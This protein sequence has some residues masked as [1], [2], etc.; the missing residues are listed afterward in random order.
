MNGKTLAGDRYV[1]AHYSQCLMDVSVT[2][3]DIVAVEV[4]NDKEEE[5]QQQQEE[6]EGEDEEVEDEEEEEGTGNPNNAEAEVAGQSAAG[7]NGSRRGLGR[8]R[9]RY[10]QRREQVSTIS[11]YFTETALVSLEGGSSMLERLRIPAGRVLA[12]FQAQEP[13]VLSGWLKHPILSIEMY[14]EPA[15]ELSTTTASPNGGNGTDNSSDAGNGTLANAD[16]KVGL[17][18]VT[19]GFLGAFVAVT[20]IVVVI[21]IVY[22]RGRVA[23]SSPGKITT[24]GGDDW[25][26]RVQATEHGAALALHALPG[27]DGGWAQGAV[28]G[29]SLPHNPNNN[30]DG[31]TGGQ[32]I[33]TAAPA[34]N[35]FDGENEQDWVAVSEAL[36]RTLQAAPPPPPLLLPEAEGDATARS[37]ATA[38]NAGL[39][40]RGSIKQKQKTVVG[41]VGEEFVVGNVARASAGGNVSSYLDVNPR[42][43]PTRGVGGSRPQPHATNDSDSWTAVTQA[44]HD[45][46][47][48]RQSVVSDDSLGAQWNQLFASG[49][50]PG[51]TGAIYEHSDHGT[52]AY[53]STIPIQKQYGGGGGTAT[54][55]SDEYIGIDGGDGDDEAGGAGADAGQE[56]HIAHQ[57]ND[58][59]DMRDACDAGK[60][61]DQNGGPMSEETIRYQKAQIDRKIEEL[62]AHD[63]SRRMVP[64]TPNHFLQRPS[65]VAAD[66]MIWERPTSVAS[67]GVHKSFAEPNHDHAASAGDPPSHFY[68]GN[69]AMLSKDLN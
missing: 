24:G 55:R 43:S 39:P 56:D 10:R 54:I 57:I 37:N 49:Q 30:D 4:E 41:Q 52:S 51:A 17:S 12:A 21:G 64:P 18:D 25:L 42:S 32:G 58:L 63:W 20:L 59:L 50:T 66:S 35:S 9:H 68:P 15:V 11:F 3:L 53:L 31:G 22:V 48:N 14:R 5:E 34:V 67:G 38:R 28:G 69:S 7:T 1:G 47:G 2:I 26:N 23:N 16:S 8:Q 33:A 46:A 29:F 6:E 61:N 13:S 65:S 44:L 19:L 45:G 62:R 60:L 40:V 27:G 36:H